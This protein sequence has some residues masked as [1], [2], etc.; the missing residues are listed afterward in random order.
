MA[1]RDTVEAERDTGSREGHCCGREGC[2]EGSTGRCAVEGS[3]YCC[4][5]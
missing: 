2:T 5:G 4:H 1:E 3:L